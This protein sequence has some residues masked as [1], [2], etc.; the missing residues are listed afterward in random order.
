MLVAAGGDD[1]VLGW[2]ALE[3]DD[4]VDVD[5]LAAVDVGVAGSVVAAVG[6]G[7]AVVA[8]AVPSSTVVAASSG[9][10]VVAASPPTAAPVTP[11][12]SGPSGTPV[13]TA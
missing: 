8:L 10:V 6:A 12:V 1:E 4:D 7:A 3:L 2:L 11:A 13:A 5:S 9:A